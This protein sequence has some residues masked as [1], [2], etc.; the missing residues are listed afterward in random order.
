MI[1]MPVCPVPGL[2]YLLNLLIICMSG[3]TY[4]DL[5]ALYKST[6]VYV[7]IVHSVI[8]HPTTVI[9][10]ADLQTQLLGSAMH[11]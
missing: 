6:C 8:P 1:G 7:K 10:H 11:I 4:L 2:I 5:M 3:T 9:N